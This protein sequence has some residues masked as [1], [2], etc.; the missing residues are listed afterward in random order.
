[1]SRET[2]VEKI[3]Y[4]ASRLGQTELRRMIILERS[5][6]KSS[7]GK[8]RQIGM[9]QEHCGWREESCQERRANHSENIGSESE[10]SS[11]EQSG[12]SSV[13]HNDKEQRG[14]RRRSGPR[15]KKAQEGERRR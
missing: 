5:G 15:M 8:T 13:V 9:E 14:A 11:T 3:R 4:G 2:R 7:G 6:V 12:A 10:K 1:M